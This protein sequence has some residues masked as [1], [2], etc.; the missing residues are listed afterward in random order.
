[1]EGS[2]KRNIF[3]DFVK[4]KQR[5]RPVWKWTTGVVDTNK[6]HI[7]LWHGDP[8]RQ[9]SEGVQYAQ[10]PVALV[11]RGPG[12]SFIVQFLLSAH[13]TDKRAA[14][15]LKDVRRELDFYLLQV[16]GPD[17]W[18]YAQYHCYTAANVYSKI[19]WGWYPKGPKRLNE[20][21][22]SYIVR[23]ISIQGRKR[24]RAIFIPKR[25]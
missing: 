19:H 3:D 24:S 6:D 13:S 20:P 1:M 17:P 16:G 8:P 10:T 14:K 4:T 9:D 15:I 25:T 22:S 5:V 2:K 12:K 7:K 21:H 11:A 18:A 23:G